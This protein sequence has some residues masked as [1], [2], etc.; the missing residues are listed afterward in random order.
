[1][2]SISM[3][4]IEIVVGGVTGQ[5]V[6]ESLFTTYGADVGAAVAAGLSAETGPGAVVAGMGG[7]SLG[8]LFG[9][10][11]GDYFCS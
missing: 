7:A 8:G 3:K 11:L 6:C 2:R 4:E 9:T 10:A 5:G 1:M